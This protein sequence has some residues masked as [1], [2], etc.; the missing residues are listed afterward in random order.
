M[1]KLKI[2]IIVLL[3]ALTILGILAMQAFFLYQNLNR[4]EVQFHQSV[5]KALRQVAAGIAKYNNVKLPEKGLIV[6][7]A[8]NQYEVKVNSHI[9]EAILA[10]YLE[11]E[12]EKQGLNLP[13][14]YGIYDCITDELVY[15]DCCNYPEQSK[16][17]VKKTK[18]SKK[19]DAA[20]YFVVRFPEKESYIL[21]QTS[22]LFYFSGLILVACLIMAAA[23]FIIIRQKKYS[24]LMKDFVN[25]MTHE[26]KTPISSIKISAEV[27][28]NNPLIEQDPR[29]K[30][31]AQIIMKQN[32][33]LNDQVE[34]VLQIAKMESSSFVLKLEMVSIHQLITDLADQNRIKIQDSGGTLDLDLQATKFMAKLDRFHMTNVFAN[35]LDNAVKYSRQ[36]PVILIR[37]WNE[38]NRCVVEIKDFGIGIKKDQL[39]RLFEKFYRVS[40]GDVHNVKGFGIGLYYVKRVC[41]AHDIDVELDSVF[42]ES[43]TVKLTFKNISK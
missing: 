17:K 39:P 36:K 9:D 18:K 5:S 32:Q 40:T 43:T 14:E 33:R 25:N 2:R 24:D 34:K 8:S 23:V 11:T 22:N 3:S 42:G 31:Y 29:L 35:L 37:S 4:Q 12:F 27:L 20:Y 10:N 41:D 28:L 30:Q 26:F 1:S 21:Q 13:F 38:W 15:T 7:D 16:T 6:R 19:S